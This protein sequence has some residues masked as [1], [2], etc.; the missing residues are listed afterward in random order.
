MDSII[1]QI[2]SR[3]QVAT[4][5]VESAVEAVD[6]AAVG[7]LKTLGVG[8]LGYSPIPVT[9]PNSAIG[10]NTTHWV[11]P[12][13]LARE[14]DPDHPFKL[15]TDPRVGIS[16]RNSVVM[17]EIAGGGIR[18]TVKELWRHDD[19]TIKISG[20]LMT[21]ENGTCED[22]MQKIA[23][24]CNADENIVITCQPL[25]N[26]LGITRIVVTAVEFPATDGEENQLFNITAVSDDSYRLEVE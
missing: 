8:K 18:G 1:R 12:V 20:I 9:A 24:I 23:D 7:T 19:W 3:V 16:G 26:I 2:N 15:P 5:P 25:K 22:Y 21:D 4:Q 10:Y 6:R 17:R 14:S 11:V 13:E